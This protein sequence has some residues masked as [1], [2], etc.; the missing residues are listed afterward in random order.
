L[1]TKIAEYVVEKLSVEL[2]DDYL[3]F[4]LNFSTI[5]QSATG[6]VNYCRSGLKQQINLPGKSFNPFANQSIAGVFFC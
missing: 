6:K 4:L 3:H 5:L 2:Y 1:R